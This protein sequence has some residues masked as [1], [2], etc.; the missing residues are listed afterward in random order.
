MG[1]LSWSFWFFVYEGDGLMGEEGDR[2]DGVKREIP[3]GFFMGFSLRGPLF[4]FSARLSWKGM[5]DFGE[6]VGCG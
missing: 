4:L 2:R 1:I 5:S 6:K 3:R